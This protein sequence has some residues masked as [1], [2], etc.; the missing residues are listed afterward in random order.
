[1]YVD[2]VEEDTD[3]DAIDYIDSWE[4]GDAHDL[5]S[6]RLERYILPN[7]HSNVAVKEKKPVIHDQPSHHPPNPVRGRVLMVTKKRG[8]P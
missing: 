1:M 3:S 6:P 2:K 8:W 4:E 5:S 7:M